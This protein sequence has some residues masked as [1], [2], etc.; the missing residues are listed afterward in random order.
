MRKFLTILLAGVLLPCL[1]AVNGPAQAADEIGRHTIKLATAGAAGSPL[2]VGMDK[3]AE[4]VKANSGSKIDVQT[5][6]GGQLGGDVQVISA[7]QGGFIEMAVM[8]AGLL[9]GVE[10]NFVLLDLP[11]LFGTPQEADA[12]MD[13][14]VGKALADKLPEKGLIGLAYWELGFRELT[15]NRRPVAK[16][17]DIAGLKIRVVQSP[18]Y[19]DL[20][21]ALGANAV[22][23]PFP[24]LYTALETGT[25]DGQENPPPSILSAKFNEVQKYMTLT[26]H[27]YNPQI[28]MIGAKLWGKLNET[29]RKLLKDAALQAGDFERKLSREQAGKAV[30]QLKA[31]GMT[32]N[33]LPA[34]EIEKFREKVKPVVEKHSAKVDPA[35]M[36]LFQSEIAKVRG[37]N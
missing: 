33:E 5:F 13:G 25:V 36:Q 29:E 21:N 26:N 8:N 20:F 9:S 17:S 11:F 12:V 34:E 30:E 1:T 32:V 15:N 37:K 16:L 35:L 3:F 2:A 24:E 19:I 23:L 18:I 31:A 27:T 6:A 4:I 22:P 10:K 14:P 7:L 28:I